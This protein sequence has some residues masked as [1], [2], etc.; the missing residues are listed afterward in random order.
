MEPRSLSLTWPKRCLACAAFALAGYLIGRY[1]GRNGAEADPVGNSAPFTISPV[2]RPEEARPDPP[3]G[4]LIVDVRTPAEYA[5][6]HLAGAILLPHEAAAEALLRLVPDPRAPIALYCRSGRRS[7]LVL[8]QLRG[9]GY[10]RVVNWG[11]FDELAKSRAAIWPP[12]P[13]P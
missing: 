11:G 4:L 13:E 6:G 9:H 3:E 5:A 10:S 8:D 12:P 1:C 2:S 7:G